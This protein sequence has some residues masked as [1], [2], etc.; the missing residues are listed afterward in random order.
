MLAAEATELPSIDLDSIR[1]QFPALSDTDNGMARI[2][3]D[4]P[5]GTQVPKSVADRT[6]EC[7]LHANA[8][9][10]G[11]FETSKRATAIV[12]AARAAMADFLNA[13][14]ADEIIFGQNMTSLT[15][16]MA[17]SLAR[18]F[19]ASDENVLSQMDHDANV[20]P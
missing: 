19:C 11:Y 17:R 18:P 9:Y 4:N 2:F 8:N 3:F 1:Q 15:F 16:H 5:A 6:A 13:P 7:L 10:G 14:T 12:E 20:Q